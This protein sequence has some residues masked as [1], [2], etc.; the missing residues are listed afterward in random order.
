MPAKISEIPWV[1]HLDSQDAARA[2]AAFS[3][4]WKVRA[5]VYSGGVPLDVA[6]R[7]FRERL[8]QARREPLGVPLYLTESLLFLEQ[9]H[10]TIRDA[11]ELAMLWDQE[12]PRDVQRFQI[13]PDLA[14]RRDDGGSWRGVE[15]ASWVQGIVADLWNADIDV[16]EPVFPLHWNAP[17][18]FADWDWPLRVSTGCYDGD[19]SCFRSI[20]EP[21]QGGL[22]KL[23]RFLPPFQA[24]ATLDVLLLDHSFIE[25][26]LDLEDHRSALCRV[27][28]LPPDRPYAPLLSRLL[29]LKE[30][31]CSP[32]LV[33]LRLTEEKEGFSREDEVSFART[34]LKALTYEL[35]H[36]QPFLTA[37]FTATRDY[38]PKAIPL[39]FVDPSAPLD[40]TLSLISRPRLVEELRGTDKWLELSEQAAAMLRT[41]AGPKPVDYIRSRVLKEMEVDPDFFH[42][43]SDGATTIAE[44]RELAR[45]LGLKT[46][47]EM[48]QDRWLQARV[49]RAPSRINWQEN[50]AFRL[51]QE[52]AV[53]VWIG[54]EDPTSLRPETPFPVDKI[55]WTNEKETLTVVFTEPVFGREPQVKEI[56]LPIVG[57]STHCEF[58]LTIGLENWH[59]AGKP[60]RLQARVIVLHRNRVL[61]TTLLEG[62]LA[63][64]GDPKE[65]SIRLVIEAA[66]RPGLR[67]LGER[68]AFNAA[69]VVNRTLA[70]EPTLTS[71]LGTRATLMA[72]T[73][74]L[75]AINEIATRLSQAAMQP[76]PLDLKDDKAVSLL[77]Y[78]APKGWALYQTL[79]RDEGWEQETAGQSSIQVISAHQQA[80]LPVELFYDKPVHAD[81]QPCEHSAAALKVGRCLEDCQAR[82]DSGEVLC[83]LRF[84]GMSK[85]IERHVHDP[86]LARTSGLR[87]DEFV[88]QLEPSA[89]QKEL[90][91]LERGLLAASERNWKFDPQL[92]PS[93]EDS[94]KK[95][96]GKAFAGRAGDWNDW[97]AKATGATLLVLLPHT[98]KDP[99]S[100]AET[101]EIGN[102]SLSLDPAI[103][104]DYR[105]LHLLSLENLRPEHLGH[106]RLAANETRP[107]AVFLI[108]CET[109][110]PDHEF[111]G[112]TASFRR[113]GA[114]VVVTTIS[115]ILGRHA[116]PV[117]R[118]MIEAVKDHLE[119]EGTAALGELMTQLRR[120]LLAEGYVLV[121]GLTAYGDADWL[122]VKQR[123][124]VAE[125]VT[126]ATGAS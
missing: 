39:V 96:L 104:F 106:S 61:Q 88:L 43:E 72:L 121:I 45:T 83:P 50:D 23:I 7:V 8:H 101:M 113:Q 44:L 52:Y 62:D 60:T 84:W 79:I 94:L 65:G 118:R 47:E 114:G 37:L 80:F 89:G 100:S 17:T 110:N 1:A 103:V 34:W 27:V 26:K 75:D 3:L 36:D 59:E 40:K 46:F 33:F 56:V 54:E 11:R 87:P 31:G 49:L 68:R 38:R 120:E 107:V 98:E 57:G 82:L 15:P 4:L 55:D 109:G 32:I 29:G 105:K 102:E 111:K 85:I 112:F 117:A 63:E 124:N 51:G 115:K 78:L 16:R 9:H 21:R 125:S 58:G 12:L 13:D 19:L 73:P 18:K 93:L 119:T 92:V 24:D 53:R 69:F 122:L 90:P 48:M 14:F 22:D 99:I 76:I 95:S 20:Q 97:C 10:A 25:R 116:V 81:S 70:G 41:T 28:L 66:V 77:Q 42:H 86:Q 30:P 71:V 67:E 126:A 74:T 91:I 108:G 6:R 5:P 35:S 123:S 2:I 64:P